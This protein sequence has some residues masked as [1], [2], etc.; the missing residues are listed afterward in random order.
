[1][2]LQNSTFEEQKS[3][4]QMTF[5]YFASRFCFKNNV[6]QRELFIFFNYYIHMNG[7]ESQIGCVAYCIS[8]CLVSCI[9]CLIDDGS[10]GVNQHRSIK[11]PRPCCPRGCLQPSSLVLLEINIY[12]LRKAAPIN[13]QSFCSRSDQIEI[14]TIMSW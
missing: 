2:L 8:C 4:W 6:L 10:H 1:M 11:S 3:P 12:G 5:V 13:Q 14:I 9:V 7:F